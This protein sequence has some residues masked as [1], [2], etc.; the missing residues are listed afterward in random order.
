MRWSS[1]STRSFIT[2]TLLKNT[3][4]LLQLTAA[5]VNVTNTK[6][7]DFHGFNFFCYHSST[8]NGSPFNSPPQTLH[9][10]VLK[11]GTFRSLNVG[12]YILDCYVKSE[13]LDCAYKVFD[14]LP[15][16]DVRTWTILISGLARI[17]YLRMVME[18]F[19]EMQ[20]EGVYPNQYTL[21]AVLRCCSSVGELKMAKGIHSW[22]LVN[23]IYLDVV[24]ENS[25]LDVYMKCGDFHYAEKLFETME[26]KDT[27]TW[28]IM[29]GAYMRVGYMEKALD[30]FR[31]LLLKDV[32]SWNT[33]IDGLIQNGY[34]RTALELLYEMVKVGPAFD[35]VTFSVA[36]VLASS[37]LLLELGRQ[38]HGFVLRLGI[39]NEGFIRSSLI[40]MYGKCGK[41]HKA[42]LILRKTPQFHF[43][44]RRSKFPDDEA[45]TEIISWSSLIS[46]YVCNHEY[47]NALQTFIYMISERVWVDK[48]TVTSIAS[49]CANIGI[50]KISQ[51]V[52]AY[53]Q[54]IG[55]N[56]DVHLGSSLTDMYSKCGSLDDAR[57]VFKQTTNPNVVLWTSMISACAL[58]GQGKE[59][60][61]L[62]E[63]M[64]KEGTKPNKISFLMVLTA[65]NHAGL[66]EEGCKY[67]SL[68]EEVYGFNPSVEHLT[69]MVD[70]YGRAG[71]LNETKEFIDKNGISHLSSVW[72]SFLSSCWLHKNIEMGKWVSDKLLQLEPSDAGSY[73][74]LSNICSTE[75]RWDEAAKVRS[76]MQ[77]RRINKPPGQSWIELKNQV[78]TFVMGDRTHPQ[79]MQIYSYLDELIGRL[80]EIGYSADVKLVMQDVEEEQGEL[81]LSHHSEKLAIAY[82]I[83]STGFR[84]PITIMKNLRVCT[85][86]HNFA[87]YTSQLLGREIIL[88]DIHRFHH[89]KHGCCSCRDYW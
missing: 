38:V 55:H 58:N 53:I 18:L 47:E 22:I 13:N 4:F 29:I 86:C 34:E 3:H 77:Q 51:Q 52:H 76:L 5:T 65:C 1:L 62:F 2:A 26:N 15:D 78:H 30:L 9:A 54:K 59:A 50:L 89:F 40:D 61:Q 70:L 32:A 17:G 31:K 64:I 36:L 24:L 28:N 35:K 85:D 33:I 44:T 25:V 20:V 21:S 11:N 75:Q 72:K 12:N 74:L 39:H 41:M 67:F 42:S 23:G 80:K 82:G 37:L 46:G 73:V 83:V 84:T 48:F 71:R 66:L 69:C 19:R 81:V 16:S 88:R 14:E 87:K 79:I 63:L 43:G 8:V 60:V 45:M 6:R 57:M 27:V 10:Q 7:F 68:M 56:I 49:A